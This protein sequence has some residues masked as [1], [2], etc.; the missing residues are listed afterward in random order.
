VFMTVL[1]FDFSS[2][3]SSSNLKTRREF[4]LHTMIMMKIYVKRSNTDVPRDPSCFGLGC[5]CPC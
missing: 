2:S 1:A 4:M 5:R 3:F